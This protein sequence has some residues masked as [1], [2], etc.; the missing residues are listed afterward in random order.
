[1]ADITMCD[2]KKCDLFENCYRA[3]ANP[4]P[5]Q[6]YFL[7]LEKTGNECE[8]FAPMEGEGCE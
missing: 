7:G 2:N 8:Y 1:M 5:R 6:S 3:Q 4:S